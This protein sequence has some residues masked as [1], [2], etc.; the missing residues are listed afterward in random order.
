[1]E[2]PSAMRM[3]LIVWWQGSLLPSWQASFLQVWLQ[4]WLQLP[5]Y[6][7]KTELLLIQCVHW[8]CMSMTG[9]TY[10][11]VSVDFRLCFWF[12][13]RLAIKSMSYV[14]YFLNSQNTLLFIHRK[15]RMGLYLFP[16]SQFLY[17]II[18]SVTTS[19]IYI[20][21]QEPFLP[22]CWLRFSGV[23]WEVLPS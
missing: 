12:L 14:H 9:A 11:S 13:W 19:F 1:M 15:F 20:S 7:L 22:L 6:Q 2:N 8:A 4:V 10:S 17:D 3:S 16:T 21:F 18:T 5:T 23:W